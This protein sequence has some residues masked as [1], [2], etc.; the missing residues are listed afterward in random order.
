MFRF[1]RWTIPGLI[2][3]TALINSCG[4]IPG[5][6]SASS[7]ADAFYHS[8]IHSSDTTF[9]SEYF[10]DKK[11]AAQAEA[12]I[13]RKEM[14]YGSYISHKRTGTNRRVSIEGNGRK[15]SVTFI[16]EVSGENGKTRE[17][18]RLSRNRKSDPFL[19]NAYIIEDIPNLQDPAPAGTSSA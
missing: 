19:I 18:L 3:I 13:S 15:E 7:V 9:P 11:V 2:M 16:F 10:A 12:L 5:Q 6:S 8:Q 17:T 14:A 1:K 4:L